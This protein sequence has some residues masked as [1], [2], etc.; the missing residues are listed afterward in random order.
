MK[1]LIID[2]REPELYF[3]AVGL[4]KDGLER[5]EGLRKFSRRVAF[6]QSAGPV[7][8]TGKWGTFRR[9]QSDDLD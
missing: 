6:G 8:V 9:F 5:I 4:F 2:E 7:C 1:V 3:V